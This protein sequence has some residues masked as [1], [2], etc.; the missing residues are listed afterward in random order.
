MDDF[1]AMLI[2]GAIG[3]FAGYISCIVVDSQRYRRMLKNSFEA[4]LHQWRSGF[5][6]GWNAYECNPELIKKAYEFY[7]VNNNS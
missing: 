6:A 1:L 5:D 7:F 4:E 3:L 2:I